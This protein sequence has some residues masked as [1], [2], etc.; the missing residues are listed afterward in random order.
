MSLIA[1]AGISAGASLL[2]GY[3][4]QQ[5]QSS[6]NSTSW[7]IATHQSAFQERMANSAYQ[8]GTA[9]MKK[10]G[11]NPMLAYMQG[12][13]ATPPGASAP[14]IAE[15]GMAEGV[16]GLQSSIATA[17]EAKKLT[18]ELKNMKETEK[19]ITAQKLKTQTENTLLKANVPAAQL[20]HDATE[21]VKK[22]VENLTSSAKSNK[23]NIS[24]WFNH[25]TSG[26]SQKLTIP[27]DNYKNSQAYKDKQEH[28]KKTFKSKQSTRKYK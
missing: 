4:S 15:D 2:G 26:K 3:M 21:T 12:G 28:L 16:K 25:F 24:K 11:I 13:A 22:E 9:D 19:S 7:D 18:Q 1:A 5:S 10:A 6:A 17:F 14:V 20:K 8:R 23:N 27:K